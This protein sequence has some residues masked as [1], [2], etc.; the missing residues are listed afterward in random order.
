MNSRVGFI[1]LFGAAAIALCLMLPAHGQA[2]GAADWSTAQ[3]A[4][5]VPADVKVETGR[6]GARL[7]WKKPANAN[8]VE[9]FVYRLENYDP[10][11]TLKAIARVPCNASTPAVVTY[12]DT[13]V[14]LKHV[15]T[16]FLISR[17][18]FSNKSANSKMVRFVT[19]PTF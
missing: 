3:Q 12:T 2:Q 17:D 5:P 11:K 6:K 15:Y 9:F 1:S 14:E 10:N 8:V 19:P 13:T 16:Y 7:T 18:A 4:P